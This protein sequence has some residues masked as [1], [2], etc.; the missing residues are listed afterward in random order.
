MD[1]RTVPRGRTPSRS[2]F[3]PNTN[4]GASGFDDALP[5]DEER[6]EPPLWDD[7]EDRRDEA[8]DPRRFEEPLR[9]PESLEPSSV[10]SLKPPCEDP[11]LRFDREDRELELL[12]EDDPNPPPLVR[13]DPLDMLACAQSV[14][15]K[16]NAT[17]T[18][19]AARLLAEQSAF[20]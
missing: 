16:S 1:E 7:D 10:S 4:G 5:P 3:V 17:M 19:A 14:T 20:I 9:D 18:A 11:L 15:R 8:L 12:P 2:N 6:R 13:D